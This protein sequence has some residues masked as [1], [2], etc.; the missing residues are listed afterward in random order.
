VARQA[1]KSRP[2]ASA[3]LFALTDRRA[4]AQQL[5]TREGAAGERIVAHLNQWMR[6][7]IGKHLANLM[8]VFMERGFDIKRTSFDAIDLGGQDV[9]F[10]DIEAIRAAFSTLIFVEIKTAN[11]SRVTS[12]FGGFFFAV[13][14]AEMHAAE[15]LGNQHVVALFNSQT[16]EVLITSVSDLFTRARSRT[17]QVSLQL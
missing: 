2:P 10:G 9:D 12:G 15:Q 5:A 6:R 13:T 1:K 3:V 16:G 7:P 4:R 14:E 8:Q 17:W 11:Q